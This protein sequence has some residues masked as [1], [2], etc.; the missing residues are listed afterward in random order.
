MAIA[1]R[2]RSICATLAER[3]EPLRDQL[4]NTG[5]ATFQPVSYDLGRFA[6]VLGDHERAARRFADA[7]VLSHR[8]GARFFEAENHFAWALMLVERCCPGDADHA[9]R[10]LLTALEIAA[11]NA[12]VRV[13][14]LAADALDALDV[15]RPSAPP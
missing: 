6:T 12:Y 9:R 8:A 15:S 11:A 5:P 3:L 7:D 10:R 2:D 4:G 14:Q 1:G 13:E